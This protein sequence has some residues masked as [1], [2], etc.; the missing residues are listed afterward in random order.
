M[1]PRVPPCSTSTTGN[2]S[3]QPTHPRLRGWR[4]DFQL[5]G[6]ST[7]YVECKG[8][9]RWEDVPSF[10]ELAR[11]EDA[12][13]RTR[14]EVLLIPDFPRKVQNPAGY[15]TPILGYLF[16]GQTWSYAALGRWSGEVG[17]CHSAKSWR[18]RM[19]GNDCSMSSG[20]GAPPD[21][22]LDW[23]SAQSI[24]KGKRVSHFQAF[25]KSN[26][27]TWYPLR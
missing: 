2:G 6:D 15:D 27:D 16:D 7:V 21:I 1:K 10:P 5:K 8:G 17:F 19:S 22:S 23:I 14:S 24:V 4:P 13:D 20:D 26:V 18:D 3:P 12:A 11:Y 9:L 25:N